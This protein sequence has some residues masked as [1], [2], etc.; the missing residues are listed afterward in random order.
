[1]NVTRKTMRRVLGLDSKVRRKINRAGGACRAKINGL[2]RRHAGTGFTAE[3]RAR[4]LMRR[5]ARKT[6][7][8]R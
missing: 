6:R 5:T 7:M 3:D 2:R 4:E 1:M 8:R